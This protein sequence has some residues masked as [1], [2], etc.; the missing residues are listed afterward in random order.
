VSETHKSPKLEYHKKLAR[1]KNPY[2]SIRDYAEAYRSGKTTP[3]EVARNVLEAITASDR[4]EYPLRAFIAVDRDDV[5]SQAHAAEVRIRDGKPI[6]IFD[7]VPVA[8]KDEVDMVPYPTTVGTA[9]YQDHKAQ[10]DSTVVA[11]LRAAGALLLGKA[12]MH[13]FGVNPDGSNIHYGRIS[14]PWDL[15][16]DPGGSSGG[17]AAA[18]AAG[19]CPVSIGA[20]GGGSIR[21]PASLCGVVGLKSTYG[22]VSDFGSAS[23]GLSVGHL[24]PI[25]ASVEDVVLTYAAI[26][27]PD[28]L[29]PNSQYQPS[30]SIEGWDNPDLSGLKI[31]IFWDWFRHA[32]EQV[33][34]INQQM[35]DKLGD[36]GAEVSDIMIPE[37]DNMRI[38]HIITI[39][40]EL[41]DNA[42]D[43]KEEFTK[44]AP[45]TRINLALGMAFTSNDFIRAQRMRT[46]AMQI[47]DNIFQ[48]V[49]AIITPATGIV[50]P[51]VPLAALSEGWSDL[52][53]VTEL[54]RYAFVPNL[55]GLPAISFPV[56]Y[57]IDGMP[58][59]MQ[60]IGRHWEELLLL[61]IA[62]VAEQILE[63]KLPGVHY[64]II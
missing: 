64:K 34:S 48:E 35:I 3:V 19:F 24:G 41:A 8:I 7:G 63:R 44:L 5:L 39:L 55:T 58:V 61:R 30:M 50:A 12:N 46:R 57:N 4:L 38:A 17:S 51:P 14:N 10:I 45:S 18:T 56:G 59:G 60:V 16:S 40:A 20:D 6:S 22:R 13:E 31:G 15:L 28:P 26:A 32:D 25:G 43:Q 49:D 42:P 36:A 53:A 52:S 33:V 21:I 23:E 37:L 9:I 11:R 27:G 54:T 62:Y 1:S 47:F 2:V 29:C